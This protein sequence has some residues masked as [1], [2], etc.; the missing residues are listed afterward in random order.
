[1]WKTGLL[2]TIL[3]HLVGTGLIASLFKAQTTAMYQSVSG[4][5]V[6]LFIFA[7]PYWYTM[8]FWSRERVN[9]YVMQSWIVESTSQEQASFNLS[10]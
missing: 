2:V 5:S 7:M 1:M 4:K 6:V 10:T 8:Q 3:F 9:N